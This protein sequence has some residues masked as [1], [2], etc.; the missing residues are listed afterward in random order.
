MAYVRHL[1]MIT[2][3]SQSARIYFKAGKQR[4]GYFTHE[5]FF[6]QVRKA[7]DIFEERFPGS[8]ALVALDN[9]TTHA[10]RADNALAARHMPK[11]PGWNNK[12]ALATRMRPGTLPNGEPQDFYFPAD[13]PVHPEKFKGMAQILLERGLPVPSRAECPKFHCANKSANCCCRRIL[14]NQPDFANQKSAIEEYIH[15][16]G[17]LCI[18]YPKYHCELNFIEQVWGKAKY[19][20]R[21]LPQ[22]LNE[23]K[24]IQNVKDSLDSVTLTQ[25]QR[26]A[27]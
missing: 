23:E 11:N 18:F 22:P 3:S 5:K 4:E 2:C 16:R 7:L 15:S 25:I 9:A 12:Q 13:H 26:Y 19:Y 27:K 1:L 24:M 17:H 21:M 14:F 20:Y 10:K 8:K 6:A